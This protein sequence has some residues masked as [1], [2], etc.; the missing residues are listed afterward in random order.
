[1]DIFKELINRLELT[2]DK[3]LVLDTVPMVLMPRWFFAGIM[4]RVTAEAGPDIAARIYYQA[5]YE[6][7]YNW[8]TVQIEK[9]LKGSAVLE[10]YLSSMTHR[11]WGRF[12]II[13]FEE[14]S[15]QGVFRLHNS[16][17]ALELGR[18]GEAGCL[19]VPGALAGCVQ[20]ILEHNQNPLKVRAREVQCLSTG[21]PFCE[22]VVEPESD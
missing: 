9:G 19:W 22:Y 7:A 10:Q 4:K 13:S 3:R 16:A 5:G 18:T 12:E 14:T 11:G 17:L 20:V 21:K 6:G 8:S 15:A 2:E 1:M